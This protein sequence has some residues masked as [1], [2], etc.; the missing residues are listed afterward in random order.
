MNKFNPNSR[1]SGSTRSRI[2]RAAWIFP[3][4]M[5]FSSLGVIYGTDLQS[6]LSTDSEDSS[7]SGKE[8]KVTC[9]CTS[10]HAALTKGQI[11][12]A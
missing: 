11:R 9:S 3:S 10:R 7:V 2:E 1:K 5:C 12:S 8:S 4:S 6:L